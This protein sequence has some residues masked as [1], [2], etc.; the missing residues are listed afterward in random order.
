MAYV[1]AKPCISVKD[2]ACVAVCPADCIH[3]TVQEA[4]FPQA[5]QLFID[6]MTCTDCSLCAAQCPVAAIFQEDELPAEWSDFL[7]KN[8]Q[9]FR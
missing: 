7:A 3:P 6:P 1:I 4:A 5:E 9:Y 8:A 2:S